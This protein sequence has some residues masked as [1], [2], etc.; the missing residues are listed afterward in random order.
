MVCEMFGCTPSVAL[1]EL[2]ET[3]FGLIA[4]IAEVR[5]YRAALRQ[6]ED[7]ERN[8][9]IELEETEMTRQV[10][11]IRAL[12][13]LERRDELLAQLRAARQAAE[14]GV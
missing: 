7:A 1:R 4:A 6:I 10:R 5:A 8:P 2:E 3:P 12:V 13:A 11:E 9:K 14:R